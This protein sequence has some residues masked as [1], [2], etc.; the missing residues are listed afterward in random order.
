[1]Y[2]LAGSD[3]SATLL[4]FSHPTSIWARLARNGLSLKFNG[5][6]VP[7]PDLPGVTVFKKSYDILGRS[8]HIPLPCMYELYGWMQQH[9]LWGTPSLL[10]NDTIL[11]ANCT[12]VKACLQNRITLY[13]RSDRELN[14]SKESSMLKSKLTCWQTTWSQNQKPIG[15]SCSLQWASWVQPSRAQYNQFV[16]VRP[17]DAYQ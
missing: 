16:F 5:G 2:I 14:T 10:W 6:N 3:R 8:G 11:V 13:R 9:S 15:E 17:T 7:G 12:K 1:M 4:N